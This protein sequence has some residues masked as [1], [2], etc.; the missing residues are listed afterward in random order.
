[1]IPLL[2]PDSYSQNEQK[3]RNYWKCKITK[4]DGCTHYYIILKQAKV[5]FNYSI[6]DYI[7][8]KINKLSFLKLWKLSKTNKVLF[9]FFFFFEGS[10]WRTDVTDGQE[11]VVDKK[12]IKVTTFP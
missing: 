2:I 6:L 10:L 1:M 8:R 3:A 9:P 5:K 4:I 11:N 7:L 12:I